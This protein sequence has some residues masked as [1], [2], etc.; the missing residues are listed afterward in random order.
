[1]RIGLDVSAVLG[2]RPTGICRA[3]TGL[4][5]GLG[6]ERTGD[7][8]V[9]C[10]RLSRWRPWRR[11]RAPDAP[12][13]STWIFH[14]EL[15]DALAGSLDL[16]HGADVRLP[17]EVSC[18]LVCTFHDL[19]ALQG[20]RFTSDRF[21]EKRLRQW[22]AG[23][24][25]A[26]RIITYSEFV[27]RE[28]IQH[29]SLSKEK[30]VSIPLGVSPDFGP[31][32]PAWIGKVKRRYRLPERYIL[33]VGGLSRRKGTS[34][35]LEALARLKD[36]TLGLVICGRDGYGGEEIRQ[37]ISPLGL[38]GRVHLLG[39]LR[40][41]RDLV[42]LYSGAEVFVLPS[43]YEGFGLSALEAMACETPVVATRGG[44]I[45]EVVGE[46]ARLVPP[47]EPEALRTALEDVLDDDALRDSLVRRGRE[48]VREHPWNVTA[49]TAVKLYHSL[50]RGAPARSA[51]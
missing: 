33:A 10:A 40:R 9:L 3:I 17:G 15:P 18:P 46:A 5:D 49:R 24:R 42:A 27:R 23:A 14:R 48:R 44:A 6:R 32:P 41:D 39:H 47:K 36:P 22:E 20:D 31:S 4:V 34:Y 19:S 7:E 50:G 28:V 35:L 13:F 45:P 25:R 1:M 16:F 12:G 11:P 29:F 51:S 38:E 2:R 26:A 21:R 30:V 43:L 37:T 8:F